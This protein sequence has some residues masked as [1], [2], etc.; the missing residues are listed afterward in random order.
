MN[1]TLKYN[2]VTQA[3]FFEQYEQMRAVLKGFGH[4]VAHQAGYDYTKYRNAVAGRIKNPAMLGRILDA[5]N[6][7]YN[8]LIS[9]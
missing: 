5:C 1:D 9:K 6:V 3:E 2:I 8:Q 4:K 7:V